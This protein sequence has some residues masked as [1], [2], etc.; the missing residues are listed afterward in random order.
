MKSNLQSCDFSSDQSSNRSRPR[1]L[2]PSASP[3][4]RPIRRRAC[5]VSRIL[6]TPR[7]SLSSCKIN[8]PARLLCTV[9]CPTLYIAQPNAVISCFKGRY[10][11]TT[12]VVDEKTIETCELTR[13]LIAIK[14]SI[15]IKRFML[16]N[17]L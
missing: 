13:V 16:L 7:L 4:S 9:T 17:K 12:C 1:F 10:S 11:R 8:T 2:L 15:G 14:I 5:S 6:K 3:D